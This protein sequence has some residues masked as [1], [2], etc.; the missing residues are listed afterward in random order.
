MIARIFSYAASEEPLIYMRNRS[1][2]P[3]SDTA[4]MFLF[5]VSI[6]A[7]PIATMPQAKG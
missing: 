6:E 1:S 2:Y 4:Q 7:R 5:E 3:L